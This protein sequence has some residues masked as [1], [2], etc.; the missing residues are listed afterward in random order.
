MRR[1]EFIGLVGGAAAW[2]L[3]ARAQQ[4]RIR[5]VG[6]LDL[7]AESDPVGRAQIAAFRKRIEELG[8]TEGR[9]IRID[10][11]WAGG[12]LERARTYAKELIS[13]SPDV[14]LARSSVMA[15]LRQETRT[16]PIVFVGG[17]DPVAEGFVASLARPG[18]NITGFSN[19][20]PTMAAKRLQLLK[21]IAP[22]VARV[23]YIYDPTQSGTTQFLAELEASVSSIGVQLLATAVHDAAQIERALDALAREPNGGLFVYAGGATNA[24]RELIVAFA[25]RHRIPAV[26][27]YRYF[28]TI[29]GLVS[30][31]VD[32]AD[33]YRRAASYVD[34]ILKGEKPSDLPTQQPVKFELAINLKTAKT[35]GLDVPLHL[36]Q[37]ADEVIE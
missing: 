2:P 4:E 17:A 31:G 23:A 11:R 21:E 16:I 13:L 29:G 33:Q 6:A 15:P 3:A 7:L 5:R 37:L 24:H 22:G 35:L 27:G 14:I 18:G 19:N 26:Y 8:W 28:V 30:Y 9:T 1:R 36:Q 34:R 20:S 10:E 12:D 32:A 25:S